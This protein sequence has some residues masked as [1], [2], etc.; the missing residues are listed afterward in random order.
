LCGRREL[1][2]LV[3]GV[4][5]LC[6]LRLGTVGNLL[7]CG[8][9]VVAPALDFLARVAEFA[10]LLVD[11]RGDVLCTGDCRAEFVQHLVER[12]GDSS[13]RVV[14]SLDVETLFEVTR[15]GGF[16]RLGE[17]LGDSEQ[18]LVLFLC[19]LLE[20]FGLL[21]GLLGA[22]AFVFD[23]G[24]GLLQVGD[25]G[26]QR[27]THR[28]DAV[29]EVLDFVRATGFDFDVELAGTDGFGA[30][31]ESAQR[32]RDV[33][34]EHDADQSE[35]QEEEDHQPGDGSDAAL[36]RR[37]CRPGRD[38]QPE[39]SRHDECQQEDACQRSR[40]FEAVLRSDA[41]DD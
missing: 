37:L 7:D 23:F 39:D 24:A 9:H 6:R 12:F 36:W 40:D 27:V 5:Q 29:V 10:G 35:V 25:H 21:F 13:N 19:L 18:L 32:Q 15:G 26:L 3:G 33:A 30:L 17:P 1:V 20:A 11:H 38:V 31:A 34:A 14:V 8:G 41:V 2:H 16:H 28:P 22:L 4:F